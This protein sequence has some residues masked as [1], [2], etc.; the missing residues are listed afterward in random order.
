VKTIPKVTAL[1]LTLGLSLGALSAPA[2]ADSFAYV[3]NYRSHNVS[4]INT[5]TNAVDATVA[6]RH[7]PYGVAI[8]PDG[9]FAYITNSSSNNVSVINTATNAVDVTVAVGTTPRIVAI[10]PDGAFAYIANDHSS[11]VSVIN[12]ATN[13]VDATV[14]VGTSPFGVAITPDGAF[15]YVTNANTNNVSV[16]NTATNAVD[17]TVAV[18]STPFGVAITPD[19]NDGGDIAPQPSMLVLP[20]ATPGGFPAV[21]VLKRREDRN[22]VEVSVRETRPGGDE[23][24]FNF[25]TELRPVEFLAASDRNGNG[26]PELVVVSQDSYLVET[27]DSLTGSILG[28]L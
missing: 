24:V 21:A 2:R 27:R 14:A 28:Q 23:T 18:G 6:V 8:T 17:A 15:A 5:A 9:A 11:N 22:L 12:T 19:D 1:S 13:V 10:T 16:I 4:V 20:P 3:T 25:C 7:Y 26:Y